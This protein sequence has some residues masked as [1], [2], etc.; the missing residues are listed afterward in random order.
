V[1][2]VNDMEYGVSEIVLPVAASKGARRRGNNEVMS[3][4]GLVRATGC[5]P[6]MASVPL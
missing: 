5:N 2:I 4:P 1:F 3:R 6:A